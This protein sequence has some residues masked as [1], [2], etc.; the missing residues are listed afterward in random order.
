MCLEDFYLP[1][2]PRKA[3]GSSRCSSDHANSTQYVLVDT[4]IG[5]IRGTVVSIPA[6]S[7]SLQAIS[8][9]GKRSRLAADSSTADNSS[10]RSLSTHGLE[11]EICGVGAVVET[12]GSDLCESHISPSHAQHSV[13]MHDHACRCHDAD[14]KLQ[15]PESYDHLHSSD[16]FWPMT[17]PELLTPVSPGTPGTPESAADRLADRSP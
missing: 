12:L 4:S 13:P 8:C 3:P 10:V 11:T 16:S 6:T 9:L 14:A 17:P 1:T 15:L 5:Y 2:R 7:T